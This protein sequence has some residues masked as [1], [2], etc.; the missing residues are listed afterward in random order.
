MTEIFW[1]VRLKNTSTRGKSSQMALVRGYC[2]LKGPPRLVASFWPAIKGPSFFFF[3]PSSP[4]PLGVLMTDF[5]EAALREM[6]SSVPLGSPSANLHPRHTSH[7]PAGSVRRRSQRQGSEAAGWRGRRGGF[8]RLRR[9]TRSSVDNLIRL[10]VDRKKPRRLWHVNTST[11]MTKFKVV[12]IDG[13]LV[14]TLHQHWI[15]FQNSARQE[16]DYVLVLFILYYYF[17][18]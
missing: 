3:F 11:R 18:F 14:K 17:Y 5:L 13:F 7:L 1:G 12:L 16:L 8:T 10:H 4:P 6:A 9:S 2:L 15:S